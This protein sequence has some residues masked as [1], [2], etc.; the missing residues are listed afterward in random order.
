MLVAT[1]NDAKNADEPREVNRDRNMGSSS[2]AAGNAMYP[3]EQLQG[4]FPSGFS[5]QMT[6]AEG[7]FRC[8]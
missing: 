5:S 4:Q 2:G 3:D 6:G 7:D 8:D 1:Q